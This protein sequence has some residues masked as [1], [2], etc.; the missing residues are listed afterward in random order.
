M[1]YFKFNTFAF[2][3]ITFGV[4]MLLGNLNIVSNAFSKLWPLILIA[5][6]VGKIV[7]SFLP[8]EKEK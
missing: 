4:I 5:A 6:G 2:V 8:E 7:N 3:L 1:K